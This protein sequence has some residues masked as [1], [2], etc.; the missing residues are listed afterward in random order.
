MN[1]APE[2]VAGFVQRDFDVGIELRRYGRS[3]EPGNATAKNSDIFGC[4][5]GCSRK[6]ALTV[7]FRSSRSS[8]GG[9]ALNQRCAVEALTAAGGDTAW[10]PVALSEQHHQSRLGGVEKHWRCRTR[11]VACGV[12]VPKNVR[13]MLAAVGLSPTFAYRWLKT[14]GVHGH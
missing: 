6:A 12:V 5:T 8:G 4:M 3:A 10:R 13:D 2:P 7:R 11:I 14:N 9:Y 1:V